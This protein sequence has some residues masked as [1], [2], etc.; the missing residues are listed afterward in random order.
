M[1]KIFIALL[2]SAAGSSAWAQGYTVSK[3]SSNEGKV[4][5]TLT[6]S[7]TLGTALS[8]INQ[9]E[10]K[11]LVIKGE[12]NNADVTALNGVSI[13]TLDLSQAKGFKRF[14]NDKV[15]YVVLPNGWTREEVNTCE[16]FAK[17]KSAA[18]ASSATIL[19]TGWFYK[20][21]DGESFLYEG[22][23]N[24]ITKTTDDDHGTASV[25]ITVPL[26]N[27]TVKATYNG[28]AYNGEIVVDNGKSYGVDANAKFVNLVEHSAYYNKNNKSSIYSGP[29][30][31]VNGKYYG[32]TSSDF[33][34]LYVNQEVPFTYDNGKYAYDGSIYTHYN[35]SYGFVNATVLPVVTGF[36]G[37]YYRIDGGQRVAYEGLVY[38]DKNN[39]IHG[40]LGGSEVKT[41]TKDSYTYYGSSVYSNGYYAKKDGKTYGIIPWS[42]SIDECA[43][44]IESRG[45]KYYFKNGSGEYTEG[46]IFSNPSKQGKIF[47]YKEANAVELTHN[48]QT[49]YNN[50]SQDV[51]YSGYLYGSEKKAYI[52]GQD[53][54]LEHINSSNI[55]YYVKSDKKYIGDLAEFYKSD[56]GKLYYIE[57]T[58]VQ[59][60]PNTKPVNYYVDDEKK[61]IYNG[62]NY[63]LNTGGVSYAV[64]GGSEFEVENGSLFFV[65]DDHGIATDEVFTGLRTVDNTKGFKSDDK[66]ELT[67]VYT[68]NYNTGIIPLENATGTKSFN[69]PTNSTQV[70][71]VVNLTFEDALVPSDGIAITCYIKEGGS[72]AHTL[73]HM[74]IL[75]SQWSDYSSW[76]WFNP[77]TSEGY[78]YNPKNVRQLTVAGYPNARD[79]KCT[80][81]ENLNDEGHLVA[82]ETQV[83]DRSSAWGGK[84]ECELAPSKK[85]ANVKYVERP[86][87]PNGNS[88]FTEAHI[89]YLDL[90]N[91]KFGK[92]ENGTFKYYP[93]DMTL[94]ALFYMSSPEG[95]L[96]NVKL[97]THASQYIIPEMFLLG[98]TEIKRLCIPFNYTEFHSY[99]F[100]NSPDGILRYTTTAAE[101]G[102]QLNIE[103]VGDT[104][105][106]G[107]KSLTLA[108]TVK[109][110]GRQAFSGYDGA[111]LLEDVYVLAKEAPICVFDAFD[112]KTY[113]GN[114]SHTQEHA[115]Q[116]GNYVN[117][118]NGMAMLHFPN[119]A[120][121]QQWLNYSDM[122]RRYRLYDETGHFD[123]MGRI[124]VWPTQAQYNRSFNQALAG[125]T[126]DAWKEYDYEVTETE[127]SDWQKDNPELMYYGKALAGNNGARFASHE[128]AYNQVTED[129]GWTQD[130]FDA[131]FTKTGFGIN[132]DDSWEEASVSVNHSRPL[133]YDWEKYGG[134]HQFVVAELYDFMLTPTTP[135]PE[136]TPRFY[137]FSKYKRNIWYTICFPFNMTRKQVL[138]A[139]GNPN[140]GE[141]PVLSTLAG[142]VRNSSNLKITIEMSENLMNKELVYEEDGTTVAVGSD[143][144]TQ[145]REITNPSDDDIVIEAD[146]PYFILPHLSEDELAKAATGYRRCE[147]P[148]IADDD[149]TVHF[150]IPVRVHAVNGTKTSYLDGHDNDT[151]EKSY[152]YNYYFVG[153]YIPQAM[154]ENA[155][156]LG[157]TK[158]S[159][160]E[161]WSSLFRNSPKKDGK[162]WADNTAI[163]MALV[164]DNTSGHAGSK[165][166]LFQEDHGQ[167]GQRQNFTWNAVPVDDF[168]FFEGTYKQVRSKSTA[169]S[170]SSDEGTT[171]GIIIP[172]GDDSFITVSDSP[173]VYNLK[174]QY[175]GI[176]SDNLPKGVYVVEGKKIV[177]K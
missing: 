157:L 176:Y 21:T 38:V 138:N 174:G 10:F 140:T 11:K 54:Q 26:S 27:P 78:Y 111:A 1:K 161:Y 155:Y 121:E 57:G 115:I 147:I 53:I 117:M 104:I 5:I 20:N 45:G 101:P 48:D 167:E 134:W 6:Q 165:G 43:F 29:I 85:D 56:D 110:I 143:F 92:M 74:D 118:T 129:N 35:T 8:K 125:A 68:Y 168:I 93:A 122:T 36:E 63:N 127:P 34:I 150:P 41:F 51:V 13:P 107:P 65:V 90:E 116:K 22:D 17:L 96:E 7:G 173:K 94:S 58:S 177:V 42:K 62:H 175:V 151:K 24:N 169:F 105:D 145:Y 55:G 23:V 18:S 97:P 164:E 128:A 146:K 119:A 158:K 71:Q 148:K 40:Y 49:Y 64:I 113:V 2:L 130:W 70:T 31:N 166:Q 19:K 47:G 81:F 83:P 154:P 72:L 37:Y 44:E 52:G 14:N 136:D 123:N 108:S 25:T 131:S 152:N 28:K 89:T 32:N 59:L 15:Q 33:K 46:Y 120:D 141:Y 135:D 114:N 86:E 106:N 170:S 160:G 73:K 139:F 163:V 162:I 39:A 142:V 61:V 103:N 102:E 137:D 79:L 124:L 67:T 80:S 12:L 149:R 159:N 9:S 4:T 91:A 133:T 156:Y 3:A 60:Q 95:S 84:C 30:T 112:R 98:S 144:K 77:T 82:Y 153:N 88:A 50:G 100:L 69:Q 172:V 171:T 126:W 76:Q 66:F 75:E 109:F 99:A 87:K 132:W 16:S